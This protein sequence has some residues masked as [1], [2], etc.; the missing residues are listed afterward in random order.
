MA[1]AIKTSGIQA[2][3][4]GDPVLALRHLS[5]ALQH[6]PD[7]AELYGYIGVACG[8]LNL[9]DRAVGYLRQ[10]VRLAPESA[11]LHYNLGLA[12]E[13]AEARTEAA[14][15]FRRALQLDP[16]HERA[17]RALARLERNAGMPWPPPPSGPSAPRS[18]H[19]MP[20]PSLVL[21]VPIS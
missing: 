20:H 18:D 5:S 15:S 11:M 21:P 6:D 7:D 14:A 2:L 9:L 12:L 8:Q 16:N 19:G 17:R 13:D 1:N 4:N 3:R 10:A